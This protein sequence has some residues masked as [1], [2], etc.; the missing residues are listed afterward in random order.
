MLR[1]VDLPTR[2]LLPASALERMGRALPGVQ[3][4]AGDV[5][6]ADRFLT[7]WNNMSQQAKA[8]L[9]GSLP[10]GYADSIDQ[11]VANAGKLKAYGKVLDSRGDGSLSSFTHIGAVAEAA[12]HGL[13]GF[14]SLAAGIGANRAVALA[15]HQSIY[16]RLPGESYGR[17]GS[18]WSELPGAGV[19]RSAWRDCQFRASWRAWVVACPFGPIGGSI[20]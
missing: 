16:S 2:K 13:P 7:N 14:A 19:P 11:L 5:F 10:G 15:S 20:S 8:S 6:S 17:D 12:M 1:N 9:F 18:S 3:N 4:A